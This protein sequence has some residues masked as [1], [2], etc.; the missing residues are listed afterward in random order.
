MNDI[1]PWRRK[2]KERERERERE[3]GDS[4]IEKEGAEGEM[5]NNHMAV[6]GR[7]REKEKRKRIR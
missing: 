4:G 3:R 6:F 7:E 2:R 1:K 5:W